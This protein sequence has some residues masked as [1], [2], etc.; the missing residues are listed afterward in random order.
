[1]SSG[2]LGTAAPASADF[3]LVLE[4][5][6]ALGLVL[7]ALLARGKRYREHAWCQSAIVFLNA[8]LIVAA[9]IPSFHERVQPKIPQKL[10]RSFYA[11]ATAHAFLGTL[12]EAAGLYILLGAG[13]NILPERLRMTN[14]KAWMRGVLVLW[15]LALL[16][17]VATYIRWYIPLSRFADQR[18]VKRFLG[19]PI[20]QGS[21]DLH[22]DPLVQVRE[23]FFYV[24][25]AADDERR[26][27]KAHENHDR[28][29]ALA[30]ERDFQP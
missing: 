24:C 5:V 8:V 28:R 6:I 29:R 17:G 22:P 18:P 25:S 7:G 11:V 4:V 13:T 27:Y 9:M 3:I 23:H 1:V 20:F 14:Y 19:Q 26:G 30:E 15:W 2:F 12:A 16:L 10:G 21:A